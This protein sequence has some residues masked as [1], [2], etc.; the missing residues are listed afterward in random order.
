MSLVLEHDTNTD[1][2]DER[3]QTICDLKQLSV[4]VEPFPHVTH[5]QFI[6]PE[7]YPELCRSFPNC[8]PSTGPS[9]F[10]L[11]WGDEGY[12]RLL[13]EQPAWRALFN[14]FHSQDFVEWGKA[15]FTD[16]WKTER[17]QIDLSKAHYVPYREDRIDKE[18]ATLRKVEHEPHALWVRMDIHQGRIRYDRGVHVDHARRLISMLIY[19][20]DH[21]ESHMVG[22]ELFLH[23]GPGR[24]SERTVRITP[25]HNLMVAFP[26]TARSYHSVSKITS[27]AL[28]RNY[29]QVHISSS[30][31][32]WPRDPVPGWR[33][34]LSA[35]KR[36]L[37]HQTASV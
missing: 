24:Q 32:I 35:L 19:M 27:M 9:G 18:R 22:G 1:N 30:V 21:T 6:F 23:S 29:V 10:S 20:S 15:Q 26:C 4:Q 17:C 13:D 8:P 16:F 2:S 12:A 25:R 3:P 28:P 11:Y 14:T 5:H 7:Y 33:R 37:K 34:S 31:D 36:H